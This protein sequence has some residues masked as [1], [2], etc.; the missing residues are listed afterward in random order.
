MPAGYGDTVY[1]Y[2]HNQ[3]GIKWFTTGDYEFVRWQSCEHALVKVSDEWDNDELISDLWVR[4]D[5]TTEDMQENIAL[6]DITLTVWK[7]DSVTRV[8]K[9]PVTVVNDLDPGIYDCILS[10]DNGNGEEHMGPAIEVTI[11]AGKTTSVDFGTIIVQGADENIT[12]DKVY[13]D[14]DFLDKEYLDDIY[15][16]TPI[17]HCEY[18]D[19][20]DANHEHAIKLN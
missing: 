19:E 15:L 11:E 16:T 4:N 10:Y 7:K 6:T 9:G 13:L 8:Y 18:C 17:N 1:L 12:L 5:V 3:G 2:F 14:D 20:I